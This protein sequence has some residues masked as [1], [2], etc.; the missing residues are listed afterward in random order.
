MVLLMAVHPQIGEFR[1]DRRSLLQLTK[2]FVYSQII[3][4]RF[5]GHGLPTSMF[6][7]LIGKVLTD[8]V[9]AGQP[10][11]LDHFL[12]LEFNYECLYAVSPFALWGCGPFLVGTEYYL[13]VCSKKMYDHF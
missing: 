13:E 5:V 10:V 4:D 9:I 2:R 1:S 6:D 8:D 3:L 11:S 12:H 7:I